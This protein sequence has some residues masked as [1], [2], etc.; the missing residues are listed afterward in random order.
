MTTNNLSLKK[1]II[2]LC[3]FSW[4]ILQIANN[5]ETI[6]KKNNIIRIALLFS[7]INFLFPV[8]II[9]IAVKVNE[10]IKQMP[11]TRKRYFYSLWHLVAYS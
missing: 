1:M 7:L 6:K 10:A 11:L 8:D 3:Q 2:T 4:T 5:I 9:D